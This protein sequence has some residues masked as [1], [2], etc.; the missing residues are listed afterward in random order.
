METAREI[1]PE[2]AGELSLLDGLA[3]QA[4]MFMESARMNLQG[5][6]MNLLQLGR[7][8]AEAKPLVAHGEWAG[9]VAEN[10]SLSVRTAEQYMQAYAEFGLDPDI[11][12]LGTTKVVKLLPLPE[13]QRRAFLETHDV[14]GMSTREMDRAIREAREKARAE[15]Q[16]LVDAEREARTQAE[17]RAEA[18][19]MRPP[20]IPAEVTD[21]MR[22]KDRQLA[23]QRDE[24]QR[25]AAQAR[26]TMDNT[27]QVQT[28]NSRLRGELRDA[29]ELLRETQ[30]NLDR[31]QG[32][33]LNLRSAVSRGDAE[34]APADEV[35]PE[36]FS[37][38][39]RSF[40]GAVA[41]L[42][43]MGAAFSE[44]EGAEIAQYETLLKTVED[45]A[46]RTRQT[47]NGAAIKG[48]VIVD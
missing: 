26:E 14:A 48:G 37:Q 22:E 13:E 32:E 5:L 45:W 31:V 15:M 20:E 12:A 8:F 6:T 46:K 39:V 18:L 27:R 41:R 40:I 28:E 17:A 43:H 35:T 7:V 47:I 36:V 30:E 23:E 38:A 19:A 2:A 4:R 9:W 11:A 33:Y 10:T 24:L 16:H 29:E 34:R 42:P 1:V 44:M 21:A 25:V 3:A